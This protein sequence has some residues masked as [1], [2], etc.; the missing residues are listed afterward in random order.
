MI[1]VFVF[2]VDEE[3]SRD[4]ADKELIKAYMA[5]NEVKRSPLNEFVEAINDD[6][7]NLEN[8]WIKM[9]DDEAG[10]YSIASVH[11]D[12]LKHAGFDVSNV[13]E[14]DM[15]N[16]ANILGDDYLENSFWDSMKI[17]AAQM[18]IPKQKKV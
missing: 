18:N 4:I 5:G 15:L 9:I 7:I 12:D 6:V 3:F 8:R 17:I 2:P 10:Y 16:L 1:Y 13:T 11:I 14:C